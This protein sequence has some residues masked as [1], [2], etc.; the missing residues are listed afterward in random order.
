MLI[1]SDL[2]TSLR[3]STWL[4]SLACSAS[5]AFAKPEAPR[6]V[7]NLDGTWQ[8]EQGS[9]DSRPQAFSHTV[10]VPGLMDMAQLAFKEIGKKSPLRQAFWYRRTFRLDGAIPDV[11]ML[12]IHK[13]RYG[14]KIL[15][16]DKVAGEHLPCFTPAYLDVRELLKGGGQENE[17]VIRIGA[18]RESLPEGMPTG[19]DFEKYLFLPGIYDSVELILTGRPY[20]A[21][22]QT[23]PDIEAKT[24]RVVAEVDRL[25]RIGAFPIGARVTEVST[26]KEVG[27][28]KEAGAA[29]ISRSKGAAL[30]IDFTIPIA[31]CRL[32]SPEDPF[33][34]ELHLNTGK[35]AATIRFGM[36]TFRFDPQS[37]R[38]LLNGRTYFMRGSNV[39]IYRFFEDS[40]R[41]DR[42]WRAEWVR[43]LHKKFKSMHWN[44]L[45]YCIGFPPELWYDIADEEGFLIQDE[46]PIWLL[47]R[48]PEKPR[49]EKIIPEYTEWMRERWNH[50]C[51]VI[52]DAQNESQ[53]PET[54]KA[55]QSVR[56][57]DLSN[58]PWENG[59]AE[60]QS[61]TDC[62]E[63]HPY[64]FSR[65]WGGKAPFRIKGMAAWSGVPQLQ[66]AQKKLSVPIIINE[67]A[68][69]WLTRDGNPTCLTDKVYASLLGPNSTADQRRL[70]YARY[71]A[72]LTEFWRC[73]REVAGVLHFCGL[74]YSRPGDKPRPEGG[75]TSDHFVDLEHLTF[76]SHFEEYVREAFNPVGLMLDLW[77]EEMPA[78]AE[79]QLKV[80]VIN[81]LYQDWHGEVRLRLVQQ[82]Q[83]IQVNSQSCKVPALGR[84]IL[85]FNQ[86]FPSEPGRYT[87]AAE[88]TDASGKVIRS[89]RDFSIPARR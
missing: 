5:L 70:I 78:G 68:W 66:N 57:L 37:K 85:T 21:N 23:V 53:T 43:R 27:A 76:E 24:I 86:T 35:D 74:G 81:D 9:M 41:R 20:I 55:L 48:A 29:K 63:A 60:P 10:P 26:G 31:N 13:A 8:V 34:Y 50:P 3:L 4:L 38:A 6:T 33:L 88:L 87:I 7:V 89:L 52:W 71:L 75:A 84:E 14:T 67:Y 36:R 77:D 1:Q 46:F 64:E 18:D 17:L 25:G 49:A 61:L 65:T 47:D 51:V 19:W 30:I 44:S 82:G 80:Y 83:S 2:R 15:V 72:A 56:H 39:T 54:G 45:R 79:R 22:I 12:K 59:W 73:Q 11:A 58:R 40:E 42:P 32:W 69:L 28:S 62:V 16:N